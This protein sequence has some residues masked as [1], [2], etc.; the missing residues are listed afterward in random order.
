MIGVVRPI[1][2]VPASALTELSPDHLEA[3]LLHELAHVKRHDYLVNLLQTAA[4]TLMFYHPAAWWISAQI[5]RER[6][7]C[8]DDLAARYCGSPALYARALAAMEEVRGA[9]VP[10]FALA[11]IGNGKL[12]RRIE[13]LVASR[14]RQ[15]RHDASPFLAGAGIIVLLAAMTL[16]LARPSNLKAQAKSISPCSA[17]SLSPCVTRARAFSATSSPTS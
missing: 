14:S 11:A 9:L 15:S 17:R 8:C 10:H 16:I 1:V 12:L 5:R 7:H 4:E 3:L 13:R 6:E 2:L